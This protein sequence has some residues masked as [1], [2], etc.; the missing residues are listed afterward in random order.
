M[1][2]QAIA[3]PK[4]TDL[5]KRRPDFIAGSVF[6][7]RRGKRRSF[8]RTRGRLMTEH[9]LLDDNGDGLGTPP[10]WFTGVRATKTAANGKSVDGIRAHQM[11]LGS[12]RDGAAA[13]C[14]KRARRD[15]LVSQADRVAVAQRE[16]ERGR[17]LQ[18]TG[19]N[20][21]GDSASL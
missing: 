6:C 20:P 11:F 19:S 5:D 15:E 18:P 16:N 12:R 14:R 21:V 3:D 13:Y 8:T 7:P 2:A 17:L 9:A 1:A 4:A 10:D